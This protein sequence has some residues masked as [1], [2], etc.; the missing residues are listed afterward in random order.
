MVDSDR[1]V[2]SVKSIMGKAE[3]EVG[4]AAGDASTRVSGAKTQAE[5]VIQDAAG[6]AKDAAANLADNISNAGAAAYDRGSEL[7]ARSPGSALL[8]AGAIG[9]A[10]GVLLTKGSQPR[11][12]TLQR[13]YDRY[14]G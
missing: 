3:Q 13:Y 14:G 7:V 11:R 4:K 5:G 9:F 12:N 1:V 8:M 2:G 10:L 6:Q